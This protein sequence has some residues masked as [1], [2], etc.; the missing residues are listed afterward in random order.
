M[1]L[2]PYPQQPNLPYVNPEGSSKDATKVTYPKSDDMDRWLFNYENE[3][4]RVKTA[5]KGGYLSLEGGKLIENVPED[6]TPY[7]NRRGIEASMAIFS[8]FVSKISGTS[9]YDEIRILELVENLA[10]DLVNLYTAN[11]QKFELDPERASVVID[12]LTD[13]Y[14][15][16]LRKSIDGKSLKWML[17]SEEMRVVSTEQ[18]KSGWRKLLPI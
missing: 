17:S 6:A 9:I 8:G 18:Q 5:L 4:I 1:V 16:N 15:S 14:E 12:M 13:S 3:Y 2:Q 11:M 7:M 10:H